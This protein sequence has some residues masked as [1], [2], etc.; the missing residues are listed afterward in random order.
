MSYPVEVGIWCIPWNAGASAFEM[1]VGCPAPSSHRRIKCKTRCPGQPRHPPA[2][3]PTLARSTRTTHTSQGSPST[4]AKFLRFFLSLPG[5]GL[6]LCQRWGSS[7][8]ASG[9]HGAHNCATLAT[10]PPAPPGP[11]AGPGCHG[12]DSRFRAAGES[13]SL[14]CSSDA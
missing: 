1:D 6:T 10:S 4:I 13:G 11:A 5:M 8:V 3:R 7:L 14:C 12:W 9:S 2:A